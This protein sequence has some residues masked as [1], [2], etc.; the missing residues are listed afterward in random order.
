MV[1]KVLAGIGL[2]ACVLV[3]LGMAIGAGRRA[4]LRAAWLRTWHWRR[5]RATARR[6]A[7]RAIERLRRPVVDR[8]GNVYRP[9]SFTRKADR[10]R[11][12]H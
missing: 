9:K 7:E 2:A 11:R 8:D 1:E 4:R 6:E 10:E 5:N 3:L 12:R